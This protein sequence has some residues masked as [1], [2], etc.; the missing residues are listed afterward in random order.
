MSNDQE[1]LAERFEQNRAYLR[2]VGYRLLGSR[3]DAEDAVQETWLRLSRSDAAAI[4]NLTAWLTTVVSRVCLDRLR[5]RAAHP[6]QPLSVEVPA[7]TLAAD[8]E[9]AGAA[10]LSRR[11][12]EPPATRTADPAERAVLADS[13]GIALVV[14][15]D[16]LSPDERVALV[17]HDTF[18]LPFDQIA[19]LL[20]ISPVTAR[21]L[22]SRGRRRVRAVE[23]SRSTPAPRAQRAVV[24]AFFAA[25]HDGDFE[26]LVELLHPHAVLRAD[27]GGQR[28]EV[29]AII[30]GRDAI[31]RRAAMF[32]R[33]GAMLL[34]VL[35]NG[36]P[37]VVVLERAASVSVM[38]FTV[39]LSTA[40]DA[41]IRRVDILLDPERLARLDPGLL[42][43][44]GT[45][46]PAVTL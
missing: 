7:L 9:D 25:A 32:D 12:T 33:P 17:L 37:A 24:D 13:V 39:A 42:S 28:A 44:A 8:L 1:W 45:G 4:R 14:V 46:I 18:G 38:A 16:T 29:S 41:R 6:E 27:G 11:V 15:L 2:E 35:A 40:M 21:Q 43:V 34:P 22:A 5:D 36:L 3:V 19:Q 10:A 30:H 26:A 20:D 31:A 23:P